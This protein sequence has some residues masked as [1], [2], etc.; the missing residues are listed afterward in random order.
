MDIQHVFVLSFF[1]KSRIFLFWKKKKMILQNLEPKL[2][3]GQ[4]LNSLA[5]ILCQKWKKAWNYRN[6]PATSDFV[7]LCNKKFFCRAKK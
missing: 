7:K 4:F 1:K 6:F 3:R 5:K 2:S